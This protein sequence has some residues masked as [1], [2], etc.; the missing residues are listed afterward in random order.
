MK[1]DLGEFDINEE[2]KHEEGEEGAVGEAGAGAGEDQHDAAVGPHLLGLL[3][4]ARRA[5]GK[6][7]T[8]I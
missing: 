6:G 7:A 1:D 5:E 2:Q 4:P 8:H 3:T